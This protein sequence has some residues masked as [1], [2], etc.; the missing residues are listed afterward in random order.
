MRVLAYDPDAA[1]RRAGVSEAGVGRREL[2]AL[3]GEW[4]CSACTCR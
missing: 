3:F 4:T 1:A 2:D